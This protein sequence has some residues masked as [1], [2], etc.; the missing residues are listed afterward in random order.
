MFVPIY[1]ISWPKEITFWVE[2]SWVMNHGAFSTIWKRT[3]KHAM[4]NISDTKTKK[5]T[6]VMSPSEDNARLFF[7]SQRHCSL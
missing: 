6:H 4:E 2:L 1:L 3:P 5:G 7:L